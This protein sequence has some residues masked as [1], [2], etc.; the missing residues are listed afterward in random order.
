MN[1][2][3]L[4]Y[5]IL[6]L[7]ACSIDFSFSHLLYPAY[8]LVTYL[9]LVVLNIYSWRLYRLVVITLGVVAA[10]NLPIQLMY[11]NMSM[12]MMIS[13][14]ATN[15]E[16]SL[17]FISN[18]PMLYYLLI[19]IQLIITFFVCQICISLAHN[20]IKRILLI[21]LIVFLSVASTV[22]IKDKKQFI[23]LPLA[24]ATQN[25]ITSYNQSIE[26]MNFMQQ[27]LNQPDNW[28]PLVKNKN[29]DTYI[30]VLGESAR[31]DSLH[32]FGFKLNNTPF[33]DTAN[34]TLYTSYYSAGPN[35]FISV[36]HSFCLNDINN[37]VEYNN[38]IITLANKAG[39]ET[40]WLSNQGTYGQYDLN[41]ASIGEHAHY[42]YF[43]QMDSMKNV[44]SDEQL[45]VPF[46]SS[47]LTDKLSRKLIVIHIMGSHP[48]P[49][50]RTNGKYD[51]FYISKKVSC[52]VKSIANTDKLLSSITNIAEASH[53][54]WTLMYFSDHGLRMINNGD[55]ATL[56]HSDGA[57]QDYNVPLFISSYDDKS[58]KINRNLYSARNFIDMF[59]AWT[60]ITDPQIHNQC[61]P[62]SVP[63][64]SLSSVRGFN[65]SESLQDILKLPDE[66]L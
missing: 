56:V 4:N 64:C 8:T 13:L 40:F 27:K 24:Y 16:E 3:Y 31:K 59:S 2:N 42:S 28:S 41:V 14:L 18:I 5:I 22:S 7:F 11:G 63:T 50:D 10:I 51:E 52:Y 36:P 48:D 39:L 15:K 26:A 46:E 55:N 61:N 65:A 12:G 44:T 38:N 1:K 66:A 20:I 53:R 21:M 62:L 6:L 29:Y 17:E 58:H 33:M 60:G 25:I 43:T 9:L 35:T 23:F 30:I 54:K 37:S 47:L 34:G 32:S 57:Q 49:C 19:M 45:L